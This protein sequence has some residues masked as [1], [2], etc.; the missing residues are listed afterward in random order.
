MKLNFDKY[1]IQRVLSIST[2][3]FLLF[4]FKINAQDSLYLKRY[5]VGGVGVQFLSG[6]STDGNPSYT[7]TYQEPAVSLFYRYFFP[8]TPGKSVTSANLYLTH[9]N[10]Y[11]SSSSYSGGSG[12]TNDNGN[13]ESYRFDLGLSRLAT[14]GKR[15]GFNIGGGFGIGGLFYSTGKM[16]TNLNRVNL[17]LN[18]EIHQRFKVSKKSFLILGSKMQIESPEGF[19]RRPIF[20]ET[21]FLAYMFR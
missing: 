12:N 8:W 21:V 4:S 20:I 5:H 11:V 2:L 13:F 14:L 18:F 16:K 6:A 15:K 10:G 19:V 3:C 9:R 7:I 1:F 17:S